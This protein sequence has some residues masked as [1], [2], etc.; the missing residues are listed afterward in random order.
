MDGICIQ[1]I[2]GQFRFDIRE[3]EFLIGRAV[4]EY[5]VSLLEIMQLAGFI[6][7]L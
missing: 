5:K 3:N 4:K 2:D 1:S 7:R 6:A